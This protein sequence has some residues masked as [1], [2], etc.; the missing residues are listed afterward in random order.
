LPQTAILAEFNERL[1]N[2]GIRP[3]SKSSW[4][5]YAVRKALALHKLDET[6]RLAG[7]L[8]AQFDPERS[9][10]LTILVAE[11]IKI[12]AFRKIE[13]GEL[14]TKEIMELARALSSSVGSQKGSADLRRQ[15]QKELHDKFA[16]VIN[17]A[18]E[19]ESNAAQGAAPGLVDRVALLQRIREDVYGIFEGAQQ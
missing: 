17:K 1:A 2:R 13:D 10:Q 16:E 19:Q 5:R 9:D 12:S 4:S 8:G 15:L 6:Q 11:M 3:I 18:I 14:S 7:E